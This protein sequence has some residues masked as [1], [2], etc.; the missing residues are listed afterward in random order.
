[1]I[2]LNKYVVNAEP[3]KPLH[4][5]GYAEVANAGHV[6]SASPTSFNYR[7]QTNQTRQSVKSYNRS[8]IG[9]AYGVQRAKTVTPG[10]TNRTS[11]RPRTGIG[12][13][14][15]IPPAKG[16]SEPSGRSYNPYA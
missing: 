7:Q 13:A 11:Q 15:N 9:Q 2:D 8:I 16:F 6:G 4:S 12:Q 1:M 14:L 3:G 5:N 10:N